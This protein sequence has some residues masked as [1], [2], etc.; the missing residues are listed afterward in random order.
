MV[1]A[2]NNWVVGLARRCR[3]RFDLG[4]AL[5]LSLFLQ[6]YIFFSFFNVY[7]NN[8]VYRLGWQQT[9]FLGLS[10]ILDCLW[11][12][13][14]FSTID[15]RLQVT[16]DS[17]TVHFPSA[18]GSARQVLSPRAGHHGKH[19]ANSTTV[20]WNHVCVLFN[21]FVQLSDVLLRTPRLC[22]VYISATRVAVILFRG[23]YPTKLQTFLPSRF[24]ALITIQWWYWMFFFLPVTTFVLFF[25]FS[26]GLNFK[27]FS[28]FSFCK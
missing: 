11:I 25:A 7:E 14:S 2:T 18:G 23:E 16:L 17:K 15:T 12:I 22:F 6:S 21:L 19:T 28:C 26:S 8:Q 5:A 27:S 1:W 13:I 9:E 10:G 4:P 20:Q 24:L 3:R